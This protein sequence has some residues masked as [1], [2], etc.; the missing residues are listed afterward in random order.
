MDK[1]Q[2]LDSTL[3]KQH[4]GIVGK[5]SAVQIC[6]WNKKSLTDEG[7][8]YKQ[9]FYG[10]NSHL[11]CQMAPS[12]G[13]CQNRC[14]HCW[15]AV[16]LTI[17][18][19]MDEKIIDSPEIIIEGCIKQQRK[20]LT[21]FKGNKKINLQKWKEAQE[22]MHFAI[23]L[24]GEPTLYP[25]LAELVLELKKRG[26]TTFI[27]TNGLNPAAIKALEK[28]KALPTQLYV[29]MN[30]PNEKE[31]IKWQR[32]T[33]KNPWK[34]YNQTLEL[35]KKIKKKTRTVL[36]MTLVKGENS[37][38]EPE[39]IKE[40]AA[41]IKKAE[42]WFVEV[43]AFMSVGF[44]RDRKGMGFE[45][46]PM[47]TEIKDFAEALAKELKKDDYQVLDEHM[48]SRIVLLGKD[49]EGMKIK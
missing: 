3:K 7:F 1:K 4:Y 14:L 30:S 32:T 43:K 9:K 16:E 41:L 33:E 15:R 48:Q 38:M 25:K 8:C 19:K 17:D 24:T 13:F 29:S 10:I 47:H 5:H 23:S 22:P 27:V 44:S 46:M 31:Y 37:N 21:G 35:L 39:T 12:S 34:K 49:K 36:R 18:D 2:K 11:C 40:Y 6:L 28:K 45:N 42:P 26:K 20:L